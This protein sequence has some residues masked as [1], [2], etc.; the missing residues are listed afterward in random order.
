MSADPSPPPP[1]AR[2]K[3]LIALT[4][5]RKPAAEIGGFPPTLH[6]LDID[7]YL[8]DYAREVL[9]AGGLPVHL[10]MDADPLDYM[11]HLDGVLLSGGAD[12]EPA[13]YDAEPDG[14]GAYE[15]E[16][17]RLE[18]A[19]LAG[20]RDKGLP[21]LGICRGLQLLAVASGG[22]L[23]QHVPEHARYDV[24]P[25]EEVH[26]IRFEPGSLL[27]TIHGAGREPR[28]VNS[29]HHQTVDRVGAGFRVTARAE[30]GTIE[31]LESED[32]S[33]VAVQWHPEMLPSREPVFDWLIAR[34][35]GRADHG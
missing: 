3:P 7:L 32:G 12:L 11:D 27:A 21:V 20:A 34:A 18:L 25:A 35:S 15:P 13:T 28:S 9:A 10:P 19:L 24:A 29:L 22:S 17:D 8:A 23:H 26:Q 31:G 30:D 6:G 14:N 2:A 33:V 1:P 16:R 5:R 4:G